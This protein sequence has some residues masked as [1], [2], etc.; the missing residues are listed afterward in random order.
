MSMM[1][2]RNRLVNF[3]LSDVEFESLRLACQSMGARSISEFARSAVLEKMTQ[4]D[5]GGAT[6][7]YQL[8]SKVA[9]LE[10]RVG[11]LLSLLAATGPSVA[12]EPMTAGLA[13]AARGGY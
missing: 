3:R 12:P 11:Q 2:P 4:A 7:V 13:V 5:G 6:R 1:N 9:E 10:T 8:D